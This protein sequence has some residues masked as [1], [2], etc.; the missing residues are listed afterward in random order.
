MHVA[1]INK[2]TFYYHQHHYLKPNIISIQGDGLLKQCKAVRTLLSISGDAQTDF[3]AK[4]GF[5][6]GMKQILKFSIC[7]FCILTNQINK[8]IYLQHGL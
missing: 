7:T 3:S 1:C 5:N 6:V 2:W 4:Y 8:Y